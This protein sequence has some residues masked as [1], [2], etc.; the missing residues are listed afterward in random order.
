MFKFL[1]KFGKCA[2]TICLNKLY[3]PFSIFFPFGTL[4]ILIFAFLLESYRSQ[5]LSVFFFILFLCSPLTGLFQ[6]SYSLILWFSFL[7]GLFCCLCSLLHSSFQSLNSLVSEFLFLF[8]I[9]FLFIYLYY[10]SHFI[11][12]LIFY[13][14]WFVLLCFLFVFFFHFVSVAHWFSSR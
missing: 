8:K 5:R 13:Y 10:I 4:V 11:H 6:N 14:L 9:C 1:P 2:A 3:T 12:V 7:F